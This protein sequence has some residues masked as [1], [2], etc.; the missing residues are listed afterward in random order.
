MDDADYR[1]KIPG[2]IILTPSDNPDHLMQP[3]SRS[4]NTSGGG[5][6]LCPATT[7]DGS[8]LLFYKRLTQLHECEGASSGSSDA[9]QVA[10]A[11]ALAITSASTSLASTPASNRGRKR[12]RDQSTLQAYF[13]R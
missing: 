13:Q 2:C 5:R 7:G 4:R 3:V 11:S 10:A 6:R 8:P 1:S 12:A 9:T